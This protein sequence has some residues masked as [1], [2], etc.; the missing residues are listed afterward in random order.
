MPS[1]EDVLDANV[2]GIA[3]MRQH[4]YKEA[5]PFFKKG[6]KELWS[7]INT[8][9]PRSE[10]LKN[11][12]DPSPSI[13]LSARVDG[14]DRSN[15]GQRIVEST[16][17]V[18][19][20]IMSAQHDV[21]YL[22][23]RALAITPNIDHLL[24]DSEPLQ[25]LTLAVLLYNTGLSLHLEGLRKGH[26]YMLQQAG[27]FYDMSYS[28]LCEGSLSNEPLL[29]ALPMMAVLNNIGHI[30]AHFGCFNVTKTCKQNLLFHINE[31]NTP[32]VSGQ[33]LS[34][35]ENTFFIENCICF[36]QWEHMAA[37]AA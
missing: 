34:D 7:A 6:L 5:I 14:C 25:F 35:E 1:F 24:E 23:D 19:A 12:A 2:Q 28:L 9:M 17:I 13:F 26:S 37:P 21:F 16:P 15:L 36:P 32:A 8:S 31:L 29:S 10:R 22:F 11:I 20:S 30:H 3:L 33:S 27:Q 4:S 18:D